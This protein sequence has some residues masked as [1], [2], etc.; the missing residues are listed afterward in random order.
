MD[1]PPSDGDRA[2]SRR[3]L[4]GL[5]GA[6]GLAAATASAC[7]AEPAPR[8]SPTQSPSP[9]A[10]AVSPASRLKLCRDAWGANPPRRAGTPHTLN[11]MTIHHTAAVLGDNSNA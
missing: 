11:R 10:P 8:P 1:A 9:T 2:L 6:A 3:R 5:A 7:S 4:L